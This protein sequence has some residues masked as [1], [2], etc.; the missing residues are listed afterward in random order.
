M[1][2][3]VMHYIKLLVPYRVRRVIRRNLLLPLLVSVRMPTAPIRLL[4][5]FVIIGAKKGGTTTLYQYLIQHSSVAPALTQEIHFFDRNFQK[6]ANWY[7]AHFPMILY[8]DYVKRVRGIDLLTGEASAYYLFHPHVP[9]RMRRLIPQ[10]KLIVVL[11]NPIDRAWA[12]YHQNLKKGEHLPFDEA[13]DKERERLS[14]ERERI[15]LDENYDS[16]N[17]ARYSYLARG[18]YIDQIRVWMNLFSKEQILVLR[19]EDLL[20]D[21]PSEVVKRTVEFLGLPDWTPK[22][23]RQFNRDYYPPMRAATRKRLADYF[24]PHNQRLYEFLDTN[25]GWDG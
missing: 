10:V 2:L 12:H 4:P 8:R 14:G 3:D 18:I 15:L 7:R 21:N 19:S 11:R 13:I 1:K 17:Y 24:E 23:Y 16:V 6:G 22:T 25:L 20:F 9:D 5:N